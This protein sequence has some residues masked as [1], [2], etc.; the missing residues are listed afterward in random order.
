M[1]AAANAKKD[2]VELLLSKGAIATQ[3]DNAGKTALQYASILTAETE[4]YVKKATKTCVVD[5]AETIKILTKAI[6]NN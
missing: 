5:K 3:K 2:V 6:E 1:R 4:G